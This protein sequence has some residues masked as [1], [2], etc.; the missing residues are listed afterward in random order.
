MNSGPNKLKK[1][2]RI[3]RSIISFVL[4]AI[5]VG[6]VFFDPVHYRITDCAFKHLTGLS[7][8]GCGLTRSFHSTA[9]LHLFEGFKNHLLGP[10]L[11]LGF[12]GL[13]GVML[14]ETISG[15]VVL[16]RINKGIL[17]T[18]LISLAVFWFFYWLIRMITEFS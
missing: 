9:N 17:K 7:C 2:Q 4:L 14:Y 8:P 6:A 1:D 10:F 15:R 18:A 3:I 5:L 12:I 13:F 16:S 11:Y